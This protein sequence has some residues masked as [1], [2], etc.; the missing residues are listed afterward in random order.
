M[1]AITNWIQDMFKQCIRVAK[2][3]SEN[4]ATLFANTDIVYSQILRNT[5]EKVCINTLIDMPPNKQI[6]EAF[7]YKTKC[8]TLVVTSIHMH[9]RIPSRERENGCYLYEILM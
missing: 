1:N 3:Y 6:K 8:T 9:F 7:I 4:A 2:N 5:K